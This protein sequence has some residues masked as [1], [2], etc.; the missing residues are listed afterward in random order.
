MTYK[1]HLVYNPTATDLRQAYEVA[2]GDL[3]ESYLI[4]ALFAN[5]SD[6]TIERLYQE[7]LDKVKS[8]MDKMTVCVYCMSWYGAETQVCPECNE[9]DGMMVV[10][11]A[12]KEGHIV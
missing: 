6:Q 2:Y 7:A 9:Y 5:V 1:E 3:G 12:R 4:G 10:S 11:E 8:D